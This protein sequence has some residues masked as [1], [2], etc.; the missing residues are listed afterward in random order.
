MYQKILAPFEIIPF[1]IMN[2]REATHYFEWFVSLQSERI[3]ILTKYFNATQEGD[4]KVL[5]LTPESLIDLWSWFVPLIRKVDKSQEE[6]EDELANLPDWVIMEVMGD[7]LK[8]CD[9][10]DAIIIDIG[11]YFGAVFLQQYNQLNWGVI[12]KPKNFVDVNQP[13]ILGF[14][15]R[16]TLNPIRVVNNCAEIDFQKEM[17]YGRTLIETFQFWTKFIE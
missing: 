11:I 16:K 5:D 8:F 13:I 2:K 9:N 14:I 1:E 4:S 12:H 7:G 6:Q 17:D 3:E 10:T 15:N